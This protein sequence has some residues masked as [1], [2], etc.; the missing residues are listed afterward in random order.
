MPRKT[1]DNLYIFLWI[2]T[3]IDLIKCFAW[4]FARFWICCYR[5]VCI[6][7]LI[8][9]LIKLRGPQGSRKIFYTMD[10]VYLLLFTHKTIRQCIIPMWSNAAMFYQ[11][12]HKYGQTSV[13]S[14]SNGGGYTKMWNANDYQDRLRSRLNLANKSRFIEMNCICIWYG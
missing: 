6:Y 11:F 8:L 3:L 1:F 12:A 10:H 7:M 14:P 5:T 13:C 9:Q 2:W 4:Y